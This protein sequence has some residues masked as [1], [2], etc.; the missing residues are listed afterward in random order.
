MEHFVASDAEDEGLIEGFHGFGAVGEVIGK[1]AVK[2]A[3]KFSRDVGPKDG[4]D[5]DD[6]VAAVYFFLFDS[7]VFGD[8]GDVEVV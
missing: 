5:K 4:I 8:Y 2:P 1:D 6:N 3:F 7:Y